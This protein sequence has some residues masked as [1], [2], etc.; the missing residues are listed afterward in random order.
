MV[1][2]AREVCRGGGEVAADGGQLRFDEF[3]AE[4]TVGEADGALQMPALTAFR[5]S[6]AHLTA[7][8]TDVRRQ[9]AD[10]DADTRHW[11][12]G[13]KHSAFHTALSSSYQLP[14]FASLFDGTVDNITS[15]CTQRKFAV[16]FNCKLWLTALT[17]CHSFDAANATAVVPHREATRLIST[18]Q[19]GSGAFLTRLPDPTLRDSVIPSVSF[20]NR[21]QRRLGLYVSCLCPILEQRA[22]AGHHITQHHYLGDFYINGASHTERHNAVLARIHTALVAGTSGLGAI[23]LGDKGDGSEASRR[24]MRERHSYLNAGHIP[25]LYRLGHPH[26]LW[27]LKC[28]SPYIT[29]RALGLGS[30]RCGGAASTSDGHLIAFG[31]TEEALRATVLGLAARGDP[32]GRQLDRLTGEGFVAA[33]T[34]HYADAL[35]KGNRVKLLLV[36]T[37]GAF[38]LGLDLMLRSLGAGV[39]ASDVQDTTAYGSSKT[40]PRTFYAHHAAAISAAAAAQESLILETAAITPGAAHLAAP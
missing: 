14:D 12:D 27:E 3:G 10:L 32:T 16:I 30:S 22:A 18:S 15:R 2:G 28:Y 21:C 24:E 31:N 6:Y 11:V 8:L 17:A 38:S 20:R 19:T 34:G 40:S 7:T 13:T 37:T 39:K 9:H 23:K 26:L 36:E 35:E 33:H 5:S 25:D 1:G 29:S 4:A